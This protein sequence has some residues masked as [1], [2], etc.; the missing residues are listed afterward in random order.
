[1]APIESLEQ[2]VQSAQSQI[3]QDPVAH[4]NQLR[5]L[6]KKAGGNIILGSLLPVAPPTPVEEAEAPAEPPAPVQNDPLDIIDPTQ[7]TLAALFILSAR[8]L[9]ES[10]AP[11]P[12][13]HISNFCTNFNPEH[14]RLAPERVTMLAQ[15][16]YTLAERSQAFPEAIPLLM[17]LVRRYPPH[18]GYLTTIHPLLLAA[19]VQTR[20][21]T[22]VIPILAEGITEID[23]QISDVQYT[24]NLQYHYLGGCVYAALKRFKEAEEFFETRFK[25]AEEFFETAVTA[26]AAVASAIQLEAYKKLGLI[27]LILYGELRNPPRYVSSA[28]TR[29]YKAQTA[30]LNFAK[31]YGVANPNE[32]PAGDVESF[33]RDNNMGLLKQAI[34]RIPY[35]AVH[36]LTKVYVSLSLT[37]IGQAI[38]ISDPAAVGTLIQTMITTGEIHATISPSGIVKFEDAP[39]QSINEVEGERLLGLARA[40]CL[41]LME[42][43]KQ[44]AKSKPY[45]TAALRERE[46]S[47]AD[48]GASGFM[49]EEG[50]SLVF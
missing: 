40:Q 29:V 4:V 24:D 22:T 2:V 48:F 9:P 31:T 3:A 6:A 25:E 47:T 8:V 38:K 17:S 30:Y 28:V 45:I 14:A 19:C 41:K 37:E 33:T 15:G 34:A 39:L 13:Q 35:W 32:I 21:F 7:C 26:P 43:D 49:A 12:L 44:I 1:M 5:S 50:S 18:V 11:P 23:M 16:M 36:K 46:H 42:L 20:H 10:P 27:Q